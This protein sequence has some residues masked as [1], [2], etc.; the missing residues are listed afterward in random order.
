MN[1][2][3]DH[4]NG[5]PATTPLYSSTNGGWNSS[6]GVYTPTSGNPSTTVTIGDWAHVFTDGSTTP[7]FIAY[8]ANVSTTTITLSTTAK[9]G[10]A[11]TTA[12]TGISINVGGA[13]SG[14]SGTSGFPITFISGAMTNTPG[15]TRVR[16]N[17]KNDK[18]YS[19][20]ATMSVNPPSQL[21]AT[22]QGYTTT[23]GDGGRSIIDGGSSGASYSLMLINNGG[24]GAVFT[25][26]I[27][28]NNGA[29]GSS[30]L[31]T[32]NRSCQWVRC[33]FKN[34]KGHGWQQQYV[35]G[36]V[37][38]MF[39]DCD[40]YSNGGNGFDIQVSGS[41]VRCVA[42]G[43]VGVGFQATPGTSQIFMNCI[44]VGNTSQGFHIDQSP[45]IA[46]GC[47]AYNNGDSGFYIGWANSGTGY[48][49]LINCNVAKNAKYGVEGFASSLALG[50]LMLNCGFG[51]GS[52]ANTSGAT[53]T[54]QS[55]TVVGSVNYS[56]SGQP[57][58]DPVNGDFRISLSDAKGTGWGVYNWSDTSY[59]GRANNVAYPDI[60]AVQHLD[61]GGTSTFLAQ[62]P[63]ILDRGTPY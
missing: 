29:T 19:I 12:G 37:H 2:G 8:V 47:D 25:D 21:S 14:P 18:T 9:D 32:N 24:Q 52:N 16:V 23:F 56:G 26:L 62:P 46:Y 63:R 59:S 3:G 35:G 60:G 44:A 13:W 22:F 34:S 5:Q 6:T 7:T 31:L 41:F 48:V 15:T 10:T 39:I 28:Q 38:P 61:S 27:F 33:T 1:G 43:N 55:M 51:T 50:G 4:T 36:D 49:T 20:T 58:T 53:S 17:F 45:S 57:W 11:P 42:S 54:L 30:P 40:S